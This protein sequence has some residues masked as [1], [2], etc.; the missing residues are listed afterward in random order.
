MYDNLMKDL[1]LDPKNV[2]LLAGETVNADQNGICAGMNAIIATLP[3]ALPNSYVISS[4]GCADGPDNLH[5]SASRI[6]GIGK[7]IRRKDAFLIKV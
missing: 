6:S 3:K 2:P 4:A 5:F 1:N 7:T